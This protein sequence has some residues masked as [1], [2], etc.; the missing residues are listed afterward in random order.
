MRVAV[1]GAGVIGVATAYE[2]WRDGHE[3]VVVDRARRARPAR[4]PSPMPAWSPR[5]RL[6]LVVAA[7][8]SRRCC[9]P[10]GATIWRCAS[11]SRPTRSSGAGA[12]NSRASARPSAPPTTPAR[13]VALC[14][15]SQER[16]HRR[17]GAI[18]ASPTAAARAARST[19]TATP[20]ALAQAAAHGA[21]PARRGRRGPRGDPRRGGAPSTRSTSRSATA[22]PAPST[23]R[24]TRA[25]TRAC[26]RCSLADWLAAARRRVAPR[27]HHPRHRDRRRPRGHGADR[28]GRPSRPTPTCWRSAARAR[29]SAAT[30]GLDL[31]I[32]PIKG[33]SVTLPIEGRNNPPT[34]L[35][36]RRGQ[37]VRL[38]QLSA[39]GCGMTAIAEFAGYDRSHRPD[40]FAP[41]L[42]AAREL[43]PDAGNYERPEY[44]GGPAADDARQPADLRPR[45]AGQPLGQHR[46]RPHGLDL[47]LRLGPDHRRP[48]R[49]PDA[50]ARRRDMLLH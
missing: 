4:P 17:R 23:R 49:R 38:R 13:K 16:L 20:R 27:P 45:P 33:Y 5:P 6:R 46:P 8:R 43:F 41:M 25:A 48:D 47:G 30:I 36:R 42:R 12:G 11:V 32:Y 19:S 9:E 44:L 34:L 14:L 7:R 1:L 37:P 39:T 24:A 3:V 31:P 2:L 10:C 28:P 35:G 40:D 15:Y 50:R 22:S 26:S 29:P 18:R 21:D